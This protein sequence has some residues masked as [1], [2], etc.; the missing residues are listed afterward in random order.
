MSEVLV[1]D[2]SADI[3][4]LA[5]T[6]LQRAGHQV[7]EAASAEEALALIVAEPPD[8]VLLDLQLPGMDGWALLAELR[9]QGRLDRTRVVLFSAHVDPA[10]LR[11]AP[12]EGASAYLVKPF[13]AQDLLA[14]VEP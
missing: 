1:V 4:L 2:D 6:L 11:R 12:Q 13:T 14:A 7:R 9:A 8:V 3:R 5:R 10:E